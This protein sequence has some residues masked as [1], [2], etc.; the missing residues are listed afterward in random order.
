MG[1]R[2]GNNLGTYFCCAL[3]DLTLILARHY[4]NVSHQFLLKDNSYRNKKCGKSQCG[5]MK[6]SN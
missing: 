1:K 4:K 3:V 5:E 6:R 2:C